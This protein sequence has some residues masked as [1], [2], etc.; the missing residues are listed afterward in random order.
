MGYP[1]WLAG[2]SQA[3][4]NGLNCS[5]DSLL[6]KEIFDTGLNYMSHAGFA[7]NTNELPRN[8]DT[9]CGIAELENLEFDTPPDFQ[10]AVGFASYPSALLRF[11]E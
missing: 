2:E 8:G 6:C 10:V 11:P 3:V 1:A 7:S 9:S 4:E 5:D